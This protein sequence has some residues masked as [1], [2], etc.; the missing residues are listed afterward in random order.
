MPDLDDVRRLALALPGAS[1]RTSYGTPSFHVSR[2][3]F[4]RVTEHEGGLLLRVAD[5]DEKDAL[6]AAEPDVLFTVPHYDGHP[7]VLV[8]LDRVDAG[9]LAEL[10]TDAWRTRAGVRLRRRLDEGA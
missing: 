5:L 10:V 7:S 6:L 1:E 3:L 2:A 9:L 8:R 4:A